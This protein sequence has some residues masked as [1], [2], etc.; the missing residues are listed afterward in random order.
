MKT[1]GE[2]FKQIILDTKISNWNYDSS[3]LL[4][5]YHINVYISQNTT[6]SLKIYLQLPQQLKPRHTIVIHF[7]I[8]Y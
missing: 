1:K 3:C 8:V 4:K 2:L 7:S 6:S 5:S